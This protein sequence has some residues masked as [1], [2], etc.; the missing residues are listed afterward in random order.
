MKLTKEDLDI[1]EAADESIY[2]RHEKELLRL[3][4][5]GMWA[6][7]HAIEALQYGARADQSVASAYAEDA[8]EALPK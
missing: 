6:E 7:E 4:R 8:L 5:L 3:A 1:I 2:P